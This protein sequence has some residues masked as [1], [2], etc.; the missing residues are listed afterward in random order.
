VTVKLFPSL[1]EPSVTETDTVADPASE[2]PG[3][4]ATFPVAVPV[5]GVV[6]VTV[7]YVGPDTFANVSAFPSW[8]VAESGLLVV[9]PSFTVT[10]AGCAKTGAWF[11]PAVTVMVRD[12]VFVAVPSVAL[13]DADEVPTVSVA[14]AARWMFPVAVPVPG[15]VVVTVM[16]VG[17]VTFA[18]V[19]A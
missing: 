15:V 4:R 2:N 11:A 7:A 9:V 14:P 18:N 13:T 12:F 16:N 1:A 3:A 19:R 8:S 6:V 10:L 17:P 5:P